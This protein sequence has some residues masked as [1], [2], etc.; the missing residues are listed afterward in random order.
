MTSKDKR[1][2]AFQRSTF[3]AAL[4]DWESRQLAAFPHRREL[5]ETVVAAMNDFI[6]SDQVK[7]YKMI[8]GENGAETD[9]P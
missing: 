3:D 9:E 7:T 6:D 8:V 2:Y 4:A 5:I 1:I